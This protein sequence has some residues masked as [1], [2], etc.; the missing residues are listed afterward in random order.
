M[1]KGLLRLFL[2][3]HG[4]NSNVVEI[5][6]RAGFDDIQKLRKASPKKLLMIKQVKLLITHVL[7]MLLVVS[8]QQLGYMGII[9]N[10][11]SKLL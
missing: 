7:K 4:I 9:L 5:L 1:E 8:V 10:Q 6:F 11:S 3:M 2:N